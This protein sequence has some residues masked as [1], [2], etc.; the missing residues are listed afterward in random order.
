MTAAPPAAAKLA[1]A[2]ELSKVTVPAVVNEI[3]PRRTPEPTVPFNE[4][5][6]V[7]AAIVIFPV[8]IPSASSAWSNVML[9][10]LVVN[11]VVPPVVANLTAESNSRYLL[12]VARVKL[13]LNTVWPEELVRKFRFKLLIDFAAGRYKVCESRTEVQLRGTSGI[14][15]R[16]V[17]G[18]S[19][20]GNLNI[21]RSCRKCRPNR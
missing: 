21:S 3:A 13:L 9:P 15:K 7:P 19:T 5:V 4:V 6:P 8:L 2:T 12:P 20:W 1:A 18:Q 16:Y 17:L 11:V 10:L 14:V